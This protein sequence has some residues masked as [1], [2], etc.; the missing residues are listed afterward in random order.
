M[1]HCQIAELGR[2]NNGGRYDKSRGVKVSL[3]MKV[4]RVGNA[5]M[6]V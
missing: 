4:D 6:L 1:K 3:A 2:R 5:V